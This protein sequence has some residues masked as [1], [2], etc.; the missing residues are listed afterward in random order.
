MKYAGLELRSERVLLRTRTSDH[1]AEL[2]SV[3]RSPGV[4]RWWDE[5]FFDDDPE[6]PAEDLTQLT[7]FADDQI[8]GMVQFHEETD[9]RYRHAGVDI[10]LAD[11]HQGKGLG[12][13]SIRLV[14]D[15]LASVGHHRVIIDP[16][17]AN[18]NAISAYSKLG[19]AP[20]GVMRQYEWSDHEQAWTD[21]LLMELLL[22]S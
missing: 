8:I 1:Q 6:V 21:G 11:D 5:S 3:F 20:I 9:E 13:E 19:F 10:A 16:N 4:Q 2:E 15:H 22:G 18:T 12:P 7:I 17:A 14:L